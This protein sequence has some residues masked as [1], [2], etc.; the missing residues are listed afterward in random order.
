MDGL[1]Y[2][3]HTPTPG[4]LE[5]K[6][7]FESVKVKQEERVV[8]VRTLDDFTQVEK[9]YLVVRNLNDFE[10]LDNLRAEWEVLQLPKR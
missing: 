7:V 9:N 1:C 3:N 10:S 8:T 5:T 4:L 6:K 2:S